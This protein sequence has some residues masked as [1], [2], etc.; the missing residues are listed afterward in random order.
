MKLLHL[1]LIAG[2]AAPT[3]SN[4][5]TAAE[6]YTIDPAHV[7][8]SFKINHAGWA[9]AHGTFKSVSGTIEFDKDDVTT[10]S[11]SAEIDPNS[12][13][14]NLEQRNSDLKS[15]DFLN[16]GEFPSITF[17]STAIEKTGDKTGKMTGNL[18]M[19]GVTVPITLDVTWSGLE[20]AFPWAPDV[21]R[22]GFT[23]T[24]VISPAAF[25]M[26]KVAEFGLGPDILVTIDVEAEKK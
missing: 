1:A 4:V 9:S 14:T 8:V 7:W 19:I 10:S 24:G 13:E 23:A 2:L 21:Q 11:V 3:F 20:A 26:T 5:A 25:N 22:T 16:T 12:V 18:T 17:E 15:P 6:T